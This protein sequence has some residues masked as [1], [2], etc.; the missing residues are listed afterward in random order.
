MKSSLVLLLCLCIASASAGADD[1]DDW[2]LKVGD[3]QGLYQRWWTEARMGYPA[4]QE[5]M[6]NLLLGPHG[7]EIKHQPR[8]GIQ[9]LYLAAVSGRPTAMLR[10]SQAI[11]NG[12]DGIA[13]SPA[14]A[15]CWSKKPAAFASRLACM[16]VTEFADRRARPHCSDLP[17]AA[18]AIDAAKLC[19]AN[20]TPA[21]L[22]PGPPPGELMMRRIAEYKRHGIELRLTGDVYEEEFE[23]FRNEY[24]RVMAE[25]IDKQFGPGYLEHLDREIEARINA[26]GTRQN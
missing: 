16:E 23:R 13:R 14:A 18:L 20:K 2:L 15:A 21:L 22:V 12:E 10:L 26:T 24:N 3:Y 25:A 6:A 9:F 5:R 8:E 11:R 1:Q 7:R 4:Q 17:G 19:L